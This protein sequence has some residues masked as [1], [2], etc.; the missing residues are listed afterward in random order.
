[1]TIGAEFDTLL[2][3]AQAGG[4]WAFAAL[5]RDLNPKLLRYLSAHAPGAAEDVAAET[6]LGVARG[7]RSFTGGE[8]AFRSWFFTIAHR[9]LVQLWRDRGRRPSSPADPESFADLAA[10]DDPEAAGVAIVSAAEA[11]RTIRAALSRD[12]AD[13][14]LLRVLAG[15]DADQ[16]AEVLGKRPATVRVLQHRALRKLEGQFSPE[17]VTRRP[18][19][20][21]AP[22]T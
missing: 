15:L 12:Q 13:V 17:P 10:P 8:G 1:M 3:A 6:W 7:L 16:V 19:G 2:A 9:Q 11:A 5:Y 4:E 18:P 20:A 14:V 22:V 21:I